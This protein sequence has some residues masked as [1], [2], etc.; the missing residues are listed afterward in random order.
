MLVADRRTWVYLLLLPR[1]VA[2]SLPVATNAAIWVKTSCALFSLA[3]SLSLRLLIAAAMIKVVSVHS[4]PTMLRMKSPSDIVAMVCR[5]TL[6]LSGGEADR[7]N[8]VATMCTWARCCLDERR[9]C[10][11][12]PPQS[13]SSAGRWLAKSLRKKL[14]E[15]S[16]ASYGEVG[17]DMRCQQLQRATAYRSTSSVD[18]GRTQGPGWQMYRVSPDLALSP[19]VEANRDTHHFRTEPTGC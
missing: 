14:P 5:P 10:C 13:T 9:T 17:R 8:E 11:N 3:A 7:L 18:H 16:T 4:G 6:E 12:R 2:S 19:A 1:E 15:R